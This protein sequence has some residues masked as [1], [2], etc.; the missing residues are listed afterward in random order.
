MKIGIIFYSTYGH[1][2]QMAQAA[3]NGLKENGI[4]GEILRVQETLPD[5]VLEKMGA[6]EAQ[7][8]FNNVK[9]AEVDD[10]VNYDGFIFAFP[11]RFGNM[12]SAFSTFLGAT[13][14]LWQSG[15]LIG[16]PFG[17]FAGSA[18]QHGGQESTLL[19]SMVPFIH[20]GM[21]F[22]GLPQSEQ[23][24]FNSTSVEG[25]SF[26]GATTI[27]AGDGSRMPSESELKLASALALRV[28]KIAEKLSA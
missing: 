1:L 12:A 14:Q 26:Y 13:G 28:G 19:T 2:Y 27:S 23:A 11:T 22:V 15:A 9:K 3:L 8:A 10:L 20:H 6:L 4:D 17:L 25:G 21:L 24:L 18:T 16:K 7:K 5:E